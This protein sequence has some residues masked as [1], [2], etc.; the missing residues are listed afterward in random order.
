MGCGGRHARSFGF[1]VYTGIT[2]EGF[3]PRAGRARDCDGGGAYCSV[4][5][6]RARD[7]I[8][9]SIPSGMLPLARERTSV[10]ANAPYTRTRP[11]TEETHRRIA[12][13]LIRNPRSVHRCLRRRESDPPARPGRGIGELEK[14]SVD[15]DCVP[16]PARSFHPFHSSPF[17][18]WLKKALIPALRTPFSR[19]YNF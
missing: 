6:G 12:H 3:I 7:G 9:N 10:H 17:R 11:E 13:N 8:R 4:R 19:N 15:E 14:G 16:A 2:F 5:V 1:R 18:T